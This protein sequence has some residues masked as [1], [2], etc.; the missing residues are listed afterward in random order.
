VHAN[1]LLTAAVESTGLSDFGDD[2]IFGGDGW[3]DGLARLIDDLPGARFNELG[4]LALGLEMGAYL[5]R[6]LRIVEYHRANPQIRD[7]DITPPVIIVGQART[8]TTLLHDALAQDSAHRV[9]MTWE[10]EQPVPPPR[11][12]TY[13]TDPRID[14]AE[15]LYAA[16]DTLIPGFRTIHQIGGRL[17]QECGRIMGTAFISTIFPYQYHVPGYMHWWLH[18]AVRDGHIAGAYVWHRRFLEVLQSEHGGERWLIKWP[19]HIWTLPQLMAQYPNALLVQTHRDV[20]RLVASNTSLS[21]ALR[22]LHSDQVD[23]EETAA[24]FAELLVDGVERSLDARLDGTVPAD[25]VIDIQFADL[26]ADPM[27]TV[28]AIYDRFGFELNPQTEARMANF[29]QSNK[30]E[31][32]GHRY[33]FADTGLDLADVRARTARYTKYFKVAEEDV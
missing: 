21:A 8:G 23:R 1:E 11:T 10:V 29:I 25:Q 31:T 28:R 26:M 12:E 5:S 16:T 30:R 32:S 7:R 13:E 27:A 9:P 15:E 18:D 4:H 33:A 20:A 2:E 22:S 24:L 17:A 6:R 14:E 3:R 19:S